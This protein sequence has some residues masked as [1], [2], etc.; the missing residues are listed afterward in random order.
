MDFTIKR[1]NH[2]KTYNIGWPKIGAHLKILKISSFP[3]FS[4]A[5]P[6][7]IFRQTRIYHSLFKSLFSTV[8][9]HIHWYIPFWNNAVHHIL[10]VIHP[11]ISQKISCCMVGKGVT[12]IFVLTSQ[13]IFT[14]QL[15][16]SENRASIP[17]TGH[18]M[19]PLTIAI[20]KTKNLTHTQCGHG[21]K[22]TV[23]DI[24]TYIYIYYVY[25]DSVL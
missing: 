13:E 6:S 24:D 20:L 5:P 23:Y 4:I 12:S 1:R 2:Q 9:P 17:S 11:T 18:R 21:L 16:L 15:T 19:F 3:P 22:C 25:Y 7:P 8:Y 10:M 14:T